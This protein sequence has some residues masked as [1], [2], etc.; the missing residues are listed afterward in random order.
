[1]HWD[2]PRKLPD[3]N[4]IEYKLSCDHVC[5]QRV[6]HTPSNRS[7]HMLTKNEILFDIIAFKRNYYKSFPR[8]HNILCSICWSEIYSHNESFVVKFD[9]EDKPNV[10][11]SCISQVANNKLNGIR[12][13]F[14]ENDTRYNVFMLR[15]CFDGIDGIIFTL[16][17]DRIYLL[18]EYVNHTRFI[19]TF[20]HDSTSQCS[21]CD[22]GRRGRLQSICINCMNVSPQIASGVNYKKIILLREFP[23]YYDLQLIIME[24]I[25]HIIV[26]RWGALRLL[27][28]QSL[29]SSQLSQ[30]QRARD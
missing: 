24:Y 23:I 21:I 4:I 14:R 7:I 13:S 25:A 29:R 10:C 17:G 9:Y 11:S 1:M 19:N 3:A 22:H 28:L 5:I 20:I 27:R 16:H 15:N 30:Q 6:N 12:S 18:R 8:A 2:T 26:S